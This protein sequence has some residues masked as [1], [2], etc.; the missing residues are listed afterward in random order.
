MATY[1]VVGN[2]NHDGR[3]YKRGDAIELHELTAPALIEM[4]VVQEEP[5]DAASQSSTE[6]AASAPR[7]AS[8]A[9]GEPIQTGEPSLD[10]PEDEGETDTAREVGPMAQESVAPAPE[11]PAATQ[12]PETLATRRRARARATAPQEPENDP[13]KDL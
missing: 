5:V 4:G 2:L 3:E 10:G 7:D 8:A 13:S 9:G 1:H 12:E 11:L 6:P